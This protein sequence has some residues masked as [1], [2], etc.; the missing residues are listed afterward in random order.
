MTFTISA[1]C[2][3]LLYTINDDKYD[4]TYFSSDG[5]KVIPIGP[6]Q[7]HIVWTVL[8]ESSDQV[9]LNNQP[10]PGHI[11]D[12]RAFTVDTLRLSFL[13]SG[14]DPNILFSYN[15]VLDKFELVA[16]DVVEVTSM[17]TGK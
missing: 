4:D 6:F 14:G 5:H 13:F 8:S 15:R 11:K 12:I 1:I 9:V 16:D 7:S 2:M 17:D 3:I 10:L